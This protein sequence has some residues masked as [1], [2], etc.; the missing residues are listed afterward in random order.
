MIGRDAFHK[1]NLDMETS[2]VR[3][4]QY[5]PGQIL[6]LHTDSAMDLKINRDGKITRWFVAVTLGLGSYVTST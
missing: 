4:L 1:L 3:L 5:N 6:H 2:M